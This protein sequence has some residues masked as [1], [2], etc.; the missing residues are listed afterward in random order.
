MAAASVGRRVPA[1]PRARPAPAPAYDGWLRD[2]LEGALYPWR[3][4]LVLS[5]VIDP[6]LLALGIVLG[7]SLV[8]CA[9]VLAVVNVLTVV[10]HARSRQ[11]SVEAL[12]GSPPEIGPMLPYRLLDR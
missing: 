11:T 3:V 1:L 6:L 2:D 7:W 12:F 9:G 5:V 8:V 4:A 10:E